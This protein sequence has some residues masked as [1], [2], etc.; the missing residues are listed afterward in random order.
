M[1]KSMSLKKIL[2]II[3]SICLLLTIG[4]AFGCNDKK[5]STQQ[6]NKVY[7]LSALKKTIAV[8]AEYQ[9]FVVD[10][11][12]GKQVKWS[13]ND[14]KVATVSND[15]LVKG[16]K[17]GTTKVIARVDGQVLECEITVKVMLENY[18]EIVFANE[19]DNQITLAVGDSYTLAPSLSDGNQNVQFSITSNSSAVSINGLTI[20][21]E[22]AVTDAIL[23][24]TCNQSGVA[25]VTLKI[26]VI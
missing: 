21:A 13:V 14:T 7:V 5:P 19:V 17:E 12:S 8:D 2:A 20:T 6:P 23:T 26:T 22:S 16:V 4:S 18:V 24:V 10:L 25:S 9:L 15:G 1:Y 3:L 11:P